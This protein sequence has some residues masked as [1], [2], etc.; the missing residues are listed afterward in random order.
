[1][2]KIFLVSSL[3][4][5]NTYARENPFFP[6]L[7]EES[8]PYT[9]NKNVKKPKLKRIS[10]SLPSTA[11]IIKKVIIEYENLDAS[12]E[13]KSIDLDNS[14]D[15]HLPIFISQNYVNDKILKKTKLSYTPVGK[16]Q[17]AKFLVSKN[18]LKIVSQDKI[19]RH[20]LLPQPHRIVIDFKNNNDI[21]NYIKSISNSVFVK[22]RVG[23][24]D[25]YYRLVLELDGYYKYKLNTFAY[26]C[27]ITL[28]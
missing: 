20:F 21:N 10:I 15:W 12:Y 14:V 26:G 28:Q 7:G 22:L 4:I 3:L 2:I 18:S 8:L 17:Y 19:I 1:M 27:L 6:F 11:R 9:S 25:G 24:H 5:M 23:N 13:T 16:I